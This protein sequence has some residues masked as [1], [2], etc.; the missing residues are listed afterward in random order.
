MEILWFSSN[1]PSVQVGLLF[2]I[3]RGFFFP[4]SNATRFYLIDNGR[5][6]KQVMRF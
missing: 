4:H 2:N 6:A 5:Q 3:G 1:F